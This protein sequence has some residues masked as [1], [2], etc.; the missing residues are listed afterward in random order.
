L[1]GQ[2]L[3]KTE[4]GKAE[5]ARR[6]GLLTAAVRSALIMVNGVDSV[7][8][9]VARGGPQLLEHL[10]HLLKLGLVAPVQG[11]PQQQPVQR[12]PAAP[13]PAPSPPP[14]APVPA[15]AAAPATPA[16]E[17][18]SES[19]ESDP[20]IDAQCRLVLARLREHFGSYT[21]D[22]AQHVLMARTVAEFNAAVDQI[23]FQLIPHLGR[24]LAQREVL[25]MR[26]PED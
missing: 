23:E 16:P 4:E 1:L 26:L 22:V 7:Q 13:S 3:C 6:S 25:L 9:L 24:K 18:E 17:P 20:R 12:A 15:P 5:V 19:D 2:I 8:A 21:V 14:P 11:Q 10:T